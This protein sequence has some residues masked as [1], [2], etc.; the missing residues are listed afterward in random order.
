LLLLADKVT[1]CFS[2]KISATSCLPTPQGSA[3]FKLIAEKSDGPD[4]LNKYI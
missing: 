4:K 1:I 3:F 2:R